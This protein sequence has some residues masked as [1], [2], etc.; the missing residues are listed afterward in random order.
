MSLTLRNLYNND[1]FTKSGVKYGRYAIG[2]SVW[3]AD[4]SSTW[5][6][7][8]TSNSGTGFSS[9]PDRV[10]DM[11]GIAHTHF[12]SGATNACTINSHAVG[13]S[14]ISAGA[15]VSRNSYYSL[16]RGTTITDH[17]LTVGD[18]ASF[19]S[20]QAAGNGPTGKALP[21]ICAP[22]CYVIAAV[23]RYSSYARSGSTL[24]VMKTDN[25]DYW[26]AM[27]GTS[28][29]TPTVAGILAQW[30][31]VKPDL[32][33]AEAKEI[34]ALTAIKDEFTQG[35]NGNHFGPNG[36]IDALAGIKLLLQRAGGIPG[37]VNGDGVVNMADVVDLIDYLIGSIPEDDP[38]DTVAADFN[39]DGSINIADVV[40]IIDFILSDN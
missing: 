34:M 20:Y 33:I 15:F 40:E 37:D 14:I 12:Y 30:L 17:T 27:S 23:S 10:T 4:G 18:I 29:A 3:A 28:M 31:Q 32:S 38:F 24:T 25:G 11:D 26:G 1:Y 35:V 9:G 2:L 39:Q 5:I 21:T 8:W 16:F 19:S 22:G 36:K 13:D 6:D 7:A